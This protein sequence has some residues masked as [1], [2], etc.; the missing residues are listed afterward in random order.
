MAVRGVGSK[1]WIIKVL[2]EFFLL[3]HGGK[4]GG[5]EVWFDT[6]MIKKEEMNLPSLRRFQK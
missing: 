5:R 6:L 3:K 1:V 4:G 2:N